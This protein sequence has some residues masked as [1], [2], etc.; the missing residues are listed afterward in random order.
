[1]RGYLDV[2]I[3]VVVTAFSFVVLRGVCENIDPFITLFVMSITASLSFNLFSIKQ[4]KSTYTVC[5]RNKWL[6]LTMSTALGLDWVCMLYSSYLS[7]PF[8]ALAGLYIFLAI[9]G[10]TK[11][12]WQTQKLI[13]LFSI[14]LLLISIIFLYYSYIVGPSSHLGYGI[15]LGGLAGIGF[16]VYIVSSRILTIKGSLTNSQVLSTRFWVLVLIAATFMPYQHLIHLSL[17]ELTKLILISYGALVIPI[18]FSQRAIMQLG[19]SLT[20]IFVGFVPPMTYLFN[21]LYTHKFILQ[22]LIV[23]III[24]L[25]LVLPNLV[26]AKN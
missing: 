12:F 6:Y 10:F 14:G 8:I 25:A 24:T 4:I 16:Y 19:S 21:V 20:S 23:C 13:N 15:L 1:M 11:L 9:L 3:Y 17:N 18:Y 7:D 22:N 5:F 26:K 2:I